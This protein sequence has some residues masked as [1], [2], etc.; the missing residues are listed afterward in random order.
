MSIP[1]IPALEQFL[2]DKARSINP[3]IFD[4]P[5]GYN[6]HVRYEEHINPDALGDDDPW[7]KSGTSYIWKV[8]VLATWD[9]NKCDW[10]NVFIGHERQPGK[11]EFIGHLYY[12]DGENDDI[13][14]CLRR[15]INLL[16]YIHPVFEDR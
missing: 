2:K 8:G 10:V 3:E 15:Y 16:D 1:M 13:G 12:Q 5:H 7:L 4:C 11:L 9:S 6:D 14:R